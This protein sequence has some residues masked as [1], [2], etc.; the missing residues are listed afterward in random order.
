MNI[1]HLLSQNHLTGAEVY[2]TSLI[3][4]QVADGHRV[5]QISNAFF[6]KSAAI[7]IPL[8]V[9]TRSRLNRI[10]NIFW[11]R[12]FI[13]E[14]KIDAIHTHSRAAV[15]L[16]YWATLGTKTALISTVHGIQ[17]PSFSKKIHNQYGQFII[18]VCENI[19]QQL[20]RD[21]KYSDRQIKVLPNGIS[22]D[23]YSYI[24]KDRNSKIKRVAIIG[25]TTGPKGQRTEQVLKALHSESLKNLQLDVSLIGGHLKDMN[26]SEDILKS[27]KEITDL[28]LNSQVYSEYDLI[29]G[30]GRVCMEALISGC[31][32]IAF[33]E[34]CYVGTVT[35]DN[36][37]LAKDSNF[38]DIHP[39]SKTPRLNEQSFLNEVLNPPQIQADHLSLIAQEDFSLASISQRITRLYESARFLKYYPHWIPTLM[40]HKIPEYELESRHKIYV[41]KSNFEKHLKFFRHR[42]FETLTFSD[43]E[44]FRT[45]KRDMSQFP[46]K[47]LML[48][49][50]DGYRDNFDNASPL[51]VKYG[52]KAQ[53]F[54][55][56]NPNIKDNNWDTAESDEPSHEIIAGEERQ[57][58]KSSAF[59]IGSHG[60]SHKKITELSTSEALQ[61]L[62][63]SK[64]ALEKELAISVNVFAFTYGIIGS[65]S[66]LLAEK[67]GY[68]Y[69]VNTDTGGLLHEQDPFA[70]FRVNIFP[71]ESLWSL[72]KKTSKWYRNYY[73][74]KRKK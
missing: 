7:Q 1:V 12:S 19:K 56:A 38:G 59:E 28:Q 39:N 69:A 27:T 68:S 34:A 3:Q 25:R 54:L 31:R 29:I 64:S 53:L 67:A 4:H 60:F 33:G 43:L 26:L 21:F 71:D 30:S 20:I 46:R 58:W 48:T 61:E 63:D 37:R 66:A 45:G 9:E 51:L 50:D 15:K 70:I 41:T 35:Q 22:S 49:F 13:K 72:Y 24:P 10:K 16:A 36:Y 74:K 73:F 62:V 40:Y 47:P 57:I 14:N 6:S 44:A 2:A 52:F 11:L 32:T 65:D 42:G 8:E 55:L 17:H 18:A 5:Y 23:L